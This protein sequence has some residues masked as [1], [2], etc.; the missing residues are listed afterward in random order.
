MFL[1]QFLQP[2]KNIIK[3]QTFL[4]ETNTSAHLSHYIHFVIHVS[5]QNNYKCN[6]V[7]LSHDTI[8]NYPH[9]L[10]FGC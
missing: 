5:M 7:R 2:Y 9:L 8:P 4:Q 1:S 10:T 6:I 3:Y